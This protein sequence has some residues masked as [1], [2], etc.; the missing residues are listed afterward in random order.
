MNFLRRIIKSFQMP[1]AHPSQQQGYTLTITTNYNCDSNIDFSTPLPIIE[2]GFNNVVGDIIVD[3]TIKSSLKKSY[4]EA[5]KSGDTQKELKVIDDHLYGN[6]WIWPF[7]DYWKAEFNKR[8]GW[9][10]AWQHKKELYIDYS[11]FTSPD[12]ILQLATIPKLRDIMIIFNINPE[13]SLKK[14]NDLIKFI[15][16]NIDIGKIVGILSEE[17]KEHKDGYIIKSE[18]SRI[19]LLRQTIASSIYNIRDYKRWKSNSRD[20]YYS[21]YFKLDF[22]TTDCPIENHFQQLWRDGQLTGIPPF[23]PGDGSHLMCRRR[24]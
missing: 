3:D 7:F 12:K 14:K 17:I 1:K 9:P 24:E 16:N 21:K 11:E 5:H 22:C 23:F 8:G 6:N 20:D 15:S 4:I 2:E 10:A 13:R 18:S 19:E